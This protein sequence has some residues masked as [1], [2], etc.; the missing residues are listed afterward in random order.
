MTKRVILSFERTD[1]DDTIAFKQRI[2]LREASKGVEI[3]LDDIVVLYPADISQDQYMTWSGTEPSEEDKQVLQS[4]KGGDKIYLWGH[5]SPNSGYIPGAFYTEIADYLAKGLN[6][7][8]FSP[9]KGA[10]DVSV[11]I[12]TGARGGQHGKNSFAALIHSYLGKIG[13]HSTVTGRL[14]ILWIDQETLRTEGTKT[15]DRAY[16][17]LSQI[18]IPISAERYKHQDAR[19]K[20]T[21]MWDP[22]E[23]EHQIRI[24]SY[25]KGLK[26]AFIVLKGQI[27]TK[28]NAPESTVLD[29]G[30]LHKK[31]LTVELLLAN[32]N[33]A[34]DTKLLE[35]GTKELYDYCEQI[36]GFD[37]KTLTDLG[38][39]RFNMAMKRKAHA[40]G[41]VR[42]N[43]GLLK[44]DPK[45][46]IEE[47]TFAELI[48]D[49]PQFKKLDE[50]VS[51]V[52]EKENV[53]EAVFDVVG[54]REKKG[55][56]NY[57]ANF[58]TVARKHLLVQ[59][60]G[61]M[62]ISD[63]LTKPMLLVNKM[64][65]TVFLDETKTLKQKEV[66]F[67]KLK[68][69]LDSYY[70][71]SLF[72]KF[73]SMVR[74]IL[75]GLVVGFKERH[76]ASFLEAIP[77]LFFSAYSQGHYSVST[78]IYSCG[79]VEKVV[80]I[81]SAALKNS[82]PENTQ[83]IHVSSLPSFFNNAGVAKDHNAIETHNEN[84]IEPNKGG[85]P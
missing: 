59:N 41:F 68:K 51:Q 24:D 10:L 2:Q 29:F 48:S 77:N 69:E 32:D 6:K 27:L 44:S 64:L 58:F 4:L 60:D 50:I 79:E 80:N 61:T 49:L 40:D 18:G 22:N 72:N 62:N 57:Y 54:S 82:A 81:C 66:V 73:K 45:R 35:S 17:A 75:F 53:P 78:Y 15:I 70:T 46:P 3:A 38:F 26:D 19:S 13:I 33:E 55:E 21:Y 36:I 20:V 30:K 25:R 56:S 7:D 8:N 42:E 71:P 47:N 83:E 84:E 43:T 63:N 12:C 34:L 5:G 28:V 11:E 52:K 23:Y 85:K 67:K 9:S 1:P 31:L 76:E 14:N 39:E 16:Y 37:Q 74:G 65:E